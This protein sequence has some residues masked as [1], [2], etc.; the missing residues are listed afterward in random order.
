MPRKHKG[1]RQDAGSDLD[2]LHNL[3]IGSPKTTRSSFKNCKNEDLPA[4]PRSRN[5][6]KQNARASTD[7]VAHANLPEAAEYCSEEYNS[8]EYSG[9]ESDYS[10]EADSPIPQEVAAQTHA[11]AKTPT[12]PFTETPIHKLTID[13]KKTYQTCNQM[14]ENK[15]VA[16][17][18]RRESSESRGTQESETLHGPHLETRQAK[19]RKPDYEQAPDG[20]KNYGYDDQDDDYI[21]RAGEVIQKRWQ[22]KRLMGRGSFGQ[23]LEALDLDT[24]ESVAVKIIKNRPAFI[25]QAGVELNILN[26]LKSN[27]VHDQHNIGTLFAL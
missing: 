18:R 3:H 2:E 4:L 5:T 23:V 9:D 13:L 7:H 6:S 20:P 8:D 15:P 14:Y 19:Q 1:G 16:T 12:R 22:V 27:D 11:E 26:F 25:L 24:M 21:W 17:R 10:D